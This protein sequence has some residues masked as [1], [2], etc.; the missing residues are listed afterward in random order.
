[1]LCHFLET[2]QENYNLVDK[3]VIE[4]GAGTGLVT[5]VCSLLGKKDTMQ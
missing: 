1:M 4:I 3:N 2:H 5:I